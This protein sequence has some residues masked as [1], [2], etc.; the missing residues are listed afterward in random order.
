LA[1]GWWH[2]LEVSAG[3]LVL[4]GLCVTGTGAVAVS[5]DGRAV[6]ATVDRR[7]DSVAIS[8][9]QAV[10]ARTLLAVVITPG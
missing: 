8:F 1:N 6:T 9:A 7:G 4:Q 10:T 2:A 5:V 3:T